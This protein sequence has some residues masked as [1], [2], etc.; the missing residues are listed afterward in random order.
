M[1]GE[2]TDSPLSDLTEPDTPVTYG[3]VKPGPE[4]PDGVLFIRGGDI[5]GGRVLTEQ[6]RTI[7][8][9]VSRQ[10]Q[11]TLLRGGEIVVSLVGN[12]GQVAIVPDTLNGANIA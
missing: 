7:T 9:E 12:P 4:D 10:Y 2:W 1:A 8:H 11:R 6:L 3:V 5:A